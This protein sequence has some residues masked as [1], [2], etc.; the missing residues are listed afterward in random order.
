MS[1]SRDGPCRHVVSVGAPPE[2]LVEYENHFHAHDTWLRGARAKGLTQ[3]TEHSEATHARRNLLVRRGTL[4]DEDRAA[5]RYRM[6]LHS[7][8][9]VRRTL[10]LRLGR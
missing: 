10:G 8:Q 3:F 6:Q 2:S 5:I 9:K 7:M 1:I 4:N